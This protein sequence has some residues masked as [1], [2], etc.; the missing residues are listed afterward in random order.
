MVLSARSR[1]DLCSDLVRNPFGSTA[2]AQPGVRPGLVRGDDLDLRVAHHPDRAAA[3]RDPVLGSGAIEVAVA[4][5]AR[6]RRDARLRA[7]GRRLGRP[8]APAAGPHLGR[9]RAGGPARLGA[10]RVR[11]RRPV[12]PAAAHRVRAGGDPDDLLRRRR[13]RLPA[14][15]RRAR[16]PGRREQ[17]PGRQRL[18]R[19]VHGLRHQRLPRPDPDG[20]ASPSRSTRSPTSPSALLLGSIRHEEPP[21]PKPE[22]R[23]PVLTEIRVGLSLVRHDPVLRAFVGAQMALAAL[24]GVFGATWFLFVLDDLQLS[25]AVLGVV[26]GVGG[27]SSFIGAVVASRATRRWG[28]GPVAI[29][30]M[31]LAA[32]GQCVHPARSG[33]PAARRGRLPGHA[34]ARRGLGGHRLRH[35]RGVRPPDARPRP[36]ARTGGVDVQGRGDARPARRDARA[37]GSW[38]R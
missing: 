18:R 7:R 15:D 27:A 24:W 38:P 30:A 37:P 3:R 25:P 26:A 14:D 34:A 20:T 9:S 4:A 22:D 35:H 12:V 33:R 5:R 13:Q 8:P 29:G 10:G 32:V 23:D 11:A 19:R 2:L 16:A 21:P 1:P 31:L 36:G 28:V 17:R 6:P